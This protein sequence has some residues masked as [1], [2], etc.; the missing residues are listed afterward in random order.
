MVKQWHVC[1]LFCFTEIMLLFSFLLLVAETQIFLLIYSYSM[2]NNLPSCTCLHILHYICDLG[3]LVVRFIFSRL[4]FSIS[5]FFLSKWKIIYNFN[6]K[7]FQLYLSALCYLQVHL[8]LWT[9]KGEWKG[10]L[11]IFFFFWTR[12]CFVLSGPNW[13]CFKY[14]A[15]GNYAHDSHCSEVK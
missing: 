12:F 2:A 1:R 5:L 4:I 15:M 8:S 6:Q 9:V 13:C 7:K 10:N 14:Y 3:P 11:N